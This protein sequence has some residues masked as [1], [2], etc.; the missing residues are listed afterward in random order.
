VDDVGKILCVTG[1]VEFTTQTGNAFSIFFSK[2]KGNL[3]IVIYDRVP[4][5]IEKGVCV[6]ITGEIKEL[7]GIP[8]IAPKYHDVIDICSP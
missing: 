8:A 3:R 2:D 1:T 4:K 7:T 6:K 5:G